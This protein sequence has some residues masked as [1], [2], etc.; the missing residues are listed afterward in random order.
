ME[1]NEDRE[2]SLPTLLLV[3]G[4]C[5]LSFALGLKIFDGLNMKLFFR[6]GFLIFISGILS[7]VYIFIDKRSGNHQD[8]EA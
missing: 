8:P 3:T 5:F 2:Y 6:I 4:F 7:G 1:K